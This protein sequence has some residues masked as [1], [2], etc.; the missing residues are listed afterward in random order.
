MNV[1]DVVLLAMAQ[2]PGQRPS[3]LGQ[4]LPFV[5][6]AGIFYFIVLLPMKR[7]QKKVQDFQGALKVGDKVVTTSGIHGAITKVHDKTVHVQIADKVRVEIS[8]SAIGG[9]Q[10]EDPVVQESSGS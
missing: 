7:R 8:R 5:L 2:P 1:H 4:L 9:L 10:G 6:I 3:L